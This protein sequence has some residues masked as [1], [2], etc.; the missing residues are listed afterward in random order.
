MSLTG[1]T[2]LAGIIGWPV[3]QSLSPRLHGYWLH[4]LAIDGAFVP[5]AVR[6]E[7]FST[8]VVGLQKAGFSGVS[9][10]VPHKEAAFALCHDCDPPAQAAGAVNLLILHAGGRIEGRNTDAPGLAAALRGELADATL[11]GKQAV[12]LGAGGAARAAVVAL[13]EL[14]VGEIRIVNRS[15]ARADQLAAALVPRVTSK[16]VVFDAVD[17]P[18][19]AREAALIVHATSAGMKGAAS[20]DVS[21]DSVPRTSVICDVVYNPLETP[22]L[23]RARRAGFKTI[24]GLGML[25]HQAVPAFGAFYGQEPKVTPGLRTFLQEALRSGK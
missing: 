16:I 1:S 17:W 22:L 21:L 18:S 10:T 25:M 8:V 11:R 20:L 15:R 13:E 4:E 23:A 12:V 5:L 6:P 7:D 24:D 14:G 19:A 9:V 3:A 2:K